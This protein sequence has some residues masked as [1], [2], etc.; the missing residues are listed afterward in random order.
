MEINITR[1]SNCDSVLELT[2]LSITFMFILRD[3]DEKKNHSIYASGSSSP[4]DEEQLKFH[5]RF[6]L[7]LWKL[8]VKKKKSIEKNAARERK[9]ETKIRPS[10]SH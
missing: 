7:F 10:N 1:C 9:I 3:D 4:P 5:K 6:S 2:S 8:R